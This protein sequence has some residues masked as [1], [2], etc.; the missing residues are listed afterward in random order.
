MYIIHMP[1][2]CMHNVEIEIIS[3]VGIVFIKIKL[4]RL[5]IAKCLYRCICR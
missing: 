5:Y 1:C 3:L 4:T 2:L